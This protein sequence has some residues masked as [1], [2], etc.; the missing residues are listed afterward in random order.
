MAVTAVNGER[1]AVSGGEWRPMV[2]ADE[3]TTAMEAAV[4]KCRCRRDKQTH[5]LAAAHGSAGDVQ[6]AAYKDGGVLVAAAG[7]GLGRA[8]ALPSAVP[9]GGKKKE[10]V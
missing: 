3:C 7:H 9:A 10:A 5:H 2:A 6:P 8:V 1:F 4:G